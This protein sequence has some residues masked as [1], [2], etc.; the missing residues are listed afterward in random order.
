MTLPDNLTYSQFLD[1][2]DRSPSLEGVWI[3]RLEHTFLSNGVV[4]PEFDIYTNEYLFLTLEDAERLMRESLVN[5]EAT[6]RFVITQLPV[7]RDIGEEIGASW[8][9]GPN[10]VLIDFRSTTTG[11]D[12]IR[13]CFFGRP[14]A[15]ILFRKG[16]IV[17]VVGRDSVRLAVVADDGPTVDRFWERYERSK[18]GMGYHA[19]A[20]DDCYYVLD[21]PG[22]CCHDH[23]DALSLMKP[24]RAVPEEIAGVLKSFIK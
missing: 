20:S 2:A 3:Y 9:Y 21:G 8:T 15:R 22:E 13:S 11:G 23:A 19:D 10:G 5:R 1:L 7:G 6:Y 12:T 16:D 24:C 17:E 18:D 14:R 4:Y